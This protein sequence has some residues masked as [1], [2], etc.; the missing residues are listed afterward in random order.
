MNTAFETKLRIIVIL[1]TIAP[2]Q[3]SAKITQCNNT[4]PSFEY[5]DENVVFCFTQGSLGTYMNMAEI[6]DL[7]GMNY[8]IRTGECNFVPTGK[9]LPVENYASK[10]INS[11]P[12]IAAEVG[13]LTL[14]T[15]KALVSYGNPE[16]PTIVSG[17][18]TQLALAMNDQSTDQCR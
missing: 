16:V 1:L 14:W 6:L 18:S 5:L 10:T 2:V 11:T 4:G 17:D 15:F 8:L 13:D 9:Y 7:D 12:V 3:I